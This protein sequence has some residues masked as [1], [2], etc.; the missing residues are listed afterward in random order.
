MRLSPEQPTP[1][2]QTS[3]P[4][5]LASIPRNW[6]E[7]LLNGLSAE[8]ESISPSE[9]IALLP[10][11]AD[12]RL[13]L[14][15]CWALNAR[16]DQLAPSLDETN[17]WRTWMIM[18][19]RGAGKT[20][21][22]A[23][24]IRHLATRADR[25]TSGPPR[26]FALI[27]ETLGDARRVMVEGVSGLLSVHSDA[28]RPLFEPSKN[29]LTWANGSIAHLFSAEDPD[30]LRGP[31]FEFAWCDEIAKWRHPQQAWDML[32]F[33]LRLGTQ[34]RALVTTTPRAIPLIK[35]LLADSGTVVS[36]T[37]TVDNAANLAASFITE[38][39]RRYTGTALGRQ[40]L[41]GELI[42]ESAGALWRRDWIDTAR[43]TEQP[44]LARIVVAVDPPVTA[45]A[46]SDACGIVVA[47]K[48]MDGRAYV[49][50]DRTIQG[51]SPDV[52]ARAAIAAYRDFSADRI[53]AEVNQG[54]DMVPLTL[55]SVDA[56]VPI[57]QVR[58]TRG[59]WLRAE[60]VAALYAEGRVIHVG[61]FPE[62]E[63][64]MLSFGTSTKGQARSPDRLDALV[65]ALTALMLETEPQPNMRVL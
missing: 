51:R 16:P 10:P 47:A 35:R 23:E 13:A 15:N 34:P 27:G 28:E 52:W 54:G 60:P 41:D 31:Q 32:Q 21:A 3:K 20:R 59:K 45:N 22:G 19:G 24:W 58:A 25:P 36:H 44:E 14:L 17:P 55:R 46:N 57:T 6:V 61:A 56:T 63:D 39:Q 30:T 33:G 65:W 7:T 5:P 4:Q 64:Q 37:R 9:L 29:Q 11:G 62:L 8:L 40:E 38:M 43:I 42:T 1:K 49:L 50:A 18:G 48:G 12:D 53:V 26:R 2:P